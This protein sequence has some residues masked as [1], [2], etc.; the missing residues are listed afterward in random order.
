MTFIRRNITVVEDSFVAEGESSFY[1]NFESIRDGS[2]AFL[3]VLVV[4]QLPQTKSECPSF[5]TRLAR[6]S[7]SCLFPIGQRYKRQ[8]TDHYTSI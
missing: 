6:E 5:R 4:E 8:D 1:A 2:L 3:L 7:L